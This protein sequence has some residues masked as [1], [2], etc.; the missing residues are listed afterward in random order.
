MRLLIW[1]D[2]WYTPA[3]QINAGKNICEVQANHPVTGE[4]PPVKLMKVWDGQMEK[5]S[6]ENESY[7]K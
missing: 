5:K 3:A 4:W 2:G 6:R 7:S 1:L